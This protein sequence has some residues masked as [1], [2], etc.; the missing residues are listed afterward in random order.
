MSLADDLISGG[1]N[2]A[3]EYQKERGKGR[4]RA[5]TLEIELLRLDLNNS[6]KS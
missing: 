3:E 4:D 6:S 5:A 2:F 1:I